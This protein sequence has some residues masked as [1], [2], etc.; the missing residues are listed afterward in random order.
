MDSLLPPSPFNQN[1]WGQ[2]DLWPPTPQGKISSVK[3]WLSQAFVAGGMV[4][5]CHPC[6]GLTPNSTIIP[7]SMVSYK[8]YLSGPRVLGFGIRTTPKTVCGRPLAAG[9][10]SSCLRC[11]GCSSTGGACG[12]CQ[13][14]LAVRTCQP[15]M[16][17][18]F[19][20][21]KLPQGVGLFRCEDGKEKVRT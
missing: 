9:G 12:H 18:C 1:F 14:T 15:A 17:L 4:P 3:S 5:G 21:Y 11:Q 10:D 19:F 6:K 13:P 16:Y 20:L 2:K 7:S 8:W